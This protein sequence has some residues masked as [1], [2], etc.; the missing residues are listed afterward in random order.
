[1]G[2]K[3]LKGLKAKKIYIYGDSELIINQVKGSYQ[4]KHP[5]LRSY[6]NLVLDLLENFKEYHFSVIPRKKNVI[7]DALAVSASVFKIPIYPNKKY[8]I[9]V[10]HKPA[11]PDNVNHWQVFDD[12]KQISRFME[13]SEEF[14]NVSID[15]ENMFEKENAEPVPESPEYLTQLEGKDIIQLKSNT[16]PRG[17]V[18]LEELFDN[19]DVARN[20]KVGPNDVEVEDCNIGTEQ[21]PKI[22]KISKNLTIENKERYIKLMK[23]F[24]DV[25]AWSYDD[26]KVYDTNVIQHTIPVQRNVKPFKQKLKGMNP[27]LLPLIEREIIKLFEAN[28]IVSLRFSKWLANLVPVRKNSGEIRVCVDFRNLNKV[29][30]KDNYPLPKMDHILQ[31]VVGSQRMSMLDGF[32]GYNR[33]VVHQNDQE[34]T[35]FTTPW[36]TFMYA[37]MPF[38]LMNAGATFQKA[39]DITFS[40]EED[41]FVV[42]YLDDITVYSNNDQDHLEH[43]K[44]VFQKCRKFGISLNPKKSN[45]AMKGGELL[46]D[47]ISEEGIKIDLSI[48][49]SIQK[50]DIPRNKKEIQSFLGKV[51]FLRRFITNF[52]EVVKHITNML[53]KDNG[54]K[55]TVEAKQSFADIKKVLTEAPVLVSLNFAKEFM[56]FSFAL[57]HTII[58]VLLQKNEQNLEQ[59][60]AF[61]NKSLRDSTLKYD[62]M[63]K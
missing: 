4:A 53:R 36:G 44:R 57:E 56:I 6:R 32:S 18:P 3:V 26:L 35:T 10:K 41:R 50:I 14:E 59:S 24:F 20:P 54:I 30:L 2:L 61:Y 1:L 33:V 46:G 12:D 8:E 22:I 9:E 25:F 27:L 63:E 47:V 39:M 40:E 37:K 31:R 15:Q 62:I 17:L 48:V 16:I 42:I 13:M 28:I 52:A 23:E 5:R 45:F 43:L 55:W 58:G 29:S 7:V 34:K 11:I 19:N 60:I 21:E 38:G 49:A 51:N